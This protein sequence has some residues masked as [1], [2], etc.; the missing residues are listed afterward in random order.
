MKAAKE[1]GHIVAV[2]TFDSSYQY[3]FDML[4]RIMPSH[5]NFAREYI[6]V[7][8]YRKSGEHLP[9]S[10]NGYIEEI[11]AYLASKGISISTPPILV[12]DSA[13]NIDSAHKAGYV[14]I[15]VDET[16]N[17]LN[18]LLMKTGLT[19]PADLIVDSFPHLQYHIDFQHKYIEEE[20]DGAYDRPLDART[21]FKLEN[22]LI[23]N[24]AKNTSV[25]QYLSV[26]G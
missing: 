8:R 4:K 1:A 11:T 15:L 17:Y 22:K 9:S 7:I 10:K 24:V 6:E 26:N 12:D 5:E 21:L 19:L 14:G 20:Y 2:A 13:I 16:N 3:I 25:T 18:T 23:T